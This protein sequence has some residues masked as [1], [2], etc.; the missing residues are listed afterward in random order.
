MRTGLNNW[1]RT[2]GAFDGVADFAAATADPANPLA[3][4]A[5]IWRAVDLC[6]ASFQC[7]GPLAQV[8]LLSGER[9][10]LLAVPALPGRMRILL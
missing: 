1:I 6:K 8:K 7:V 5:G 3:F 4:R 2:R 9:S 10:I